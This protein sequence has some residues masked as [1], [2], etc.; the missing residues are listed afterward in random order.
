MEKIEIFLV[1]GFMGFDAIAHL[2]YFEDVEALLKRRL[3][4]LGYDA[5]VYPLS[6]VP[7]GAIAKRSR[8]LMEQ[9]LAKHDRTCESVHLLGHS[10]GGLDVRLL[11]SP[12]SSFDVGGEVEA[13]FLAELETH[14]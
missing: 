2:H 4:A 13:S 5:T 7:A 14:E 1:P 8:Y 11:L 10:T 6:T 3:A 9:M 12:G